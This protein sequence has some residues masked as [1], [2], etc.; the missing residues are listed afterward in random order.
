MLTIRDTVGNTTSQVARI[1]IYGTR[2][3]REFRKTVGQFEEKLAIV[4]SR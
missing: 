3:S 2:K 1:V 4:S